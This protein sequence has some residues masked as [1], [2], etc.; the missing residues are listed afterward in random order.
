MLELCAP[1]AHS[2]HRRDTQSRHIVEAWWPKLLEFRE[3]VLQYA[4]I[5]KER[6]GK[7]I[8]NG[9]N[10]P[11]NPTQPN[12]QFRYVFDEKLQTMVKLPLAESKLRGALDDR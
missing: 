9:S 12:P 3:R 2:L 8:K 1:S 6:K 11:P 10:E 7:D 5:G 4:P